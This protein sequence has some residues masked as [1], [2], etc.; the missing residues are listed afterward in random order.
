[1]LII[2]DS[3][4]NPFCSKYDRKH[5]KKYVFFHRRSHRSDFIS[6]PSVAVGYLEHGIQANGISEEC[7]PIE[8]SVFRRKSLIDRTDKFGKSCAGSE[9]V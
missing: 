2:F 6:D 7:A 3:N 5:H 8:H 9:K 4:L 1:M